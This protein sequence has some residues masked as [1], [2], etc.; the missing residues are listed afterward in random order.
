MGLFRKASKIKKQDFYGG[1]FNSD[2]GK[3]IQKTLGSRFSTAKKK[4]LFKTMK[5]KG[6]QGGGLTKTET[7]DIIK[8]FYRDKNDRFSKSTAIKLKKPLEEITGYKNLRWGD[9]TYEKQEAA[10]D[11]SNEKFDQK[12]DSDNKEK[13]GLFAFLT[14]DEKKASLREKLF[15]RKKHKEK[16]NQEEEEETKEDKEKKK[17][18]TGQFIKKILKRESRKN[19]QKLEKMNQVIKKSNI[20]T[21][22]SSNSL[23]LNFKNNKIKMANPT[24]DPLTT[25]G[26]QNQNNDL[27]SLKGQGFPAPNQVQPNARP[28]R[29]SGD[30]INNQN[31]NPDLSVSG[32]SAQTKK[33]DELPQGADLSQVKNIQTTP[34]EK[35]NPPE[36]DQGNDFKN[37]NDQLD[38]D[39]QASKNNIDQ[40]QTQSKQNIPSDSVDDKE[41]DQ[42]NTYHLKE[43]LDPPNTVK[44]K[45]KQEKIEE[46]LFLTVI[47]ILLTDRAQSAPKINLILTKNGRLFIG[48]MG[49]P[50][51]RKCMKNCSSIITLIAQTTL[52][53]LKDLERELNQVQDVIIKTQRMPS[54]E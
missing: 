17:I 31:P 34:Q 37:S 26:Q 52:D 38:Q 48:R 8:T 2:L 3:K 7:E 10:K 50:L 15:N 54:L 19:R 28:N 45:A 5:K 30:Q 9:N 41:P 14:K 4:A 12:K 1:Y 53:E 13:E 21:K 46:K 39:K 51:A 27:N 11:F 22:N 35:Q 23:N 29:A 36:P 18:S 24:N 44:R 16:E 43:K 20:Q 40:D 47:S 49:I 33:K 42:S 25:N 6:R 32:D